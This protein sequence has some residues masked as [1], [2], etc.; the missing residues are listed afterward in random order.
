MCIGT[1]KQVDVLL[2]CQGA[3]F[4]CEIS[5]G[6]C[7]CKYVVNVTN[8]NNEELN[9]NNKIKLLRVSLKYFLNIFPLGL[10]IK[11]LRY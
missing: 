11:M 3:S 2:W 1:Q 7:G 5:Y 9:K 8:K 4:R 6:C 10:L